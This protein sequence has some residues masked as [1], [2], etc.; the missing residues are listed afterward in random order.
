MNSELLKALIEFHKIIGRRHHGRMPEEVETS[1]NRC[2]ELI[3]RYPFEPAKGP[4]LPS[5]NK[6]CRCCK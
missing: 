4:K 1:Y 6:C 3:N 5:I 2:S